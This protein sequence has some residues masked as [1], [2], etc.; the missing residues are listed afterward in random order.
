MILKVLKLD[1][2]L[3]I[4]NPDGPDVLNTTEPGY[5]YYVAGLDKDE[6]QLLADYQETYQVSRE[7]A[8]YQLL[9]GSIAAACEAPVPVDRR[10]L[11]HA[12]PIDIRYSKHPEA[13]KPNSASS[14]TKQN[15]K[16]IDD[17]FWDYLGIPPTEHK[18]PPTEKKGETRIVQV[19]IS[20]EGQ[21]ENGT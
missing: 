12:Q 4:E 7:D 20:D 13:D 8:L 15:E 21:S 17:L 3:W 14:L 16:V 5:I 2:T 19:D 9:M 18:E 6:Q 10:H 1:K 11:H